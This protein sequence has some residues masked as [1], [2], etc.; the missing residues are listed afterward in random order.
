MNIAHPS[1]R[2]VLE[3]FFS[4]AHVD[5]PL[6]DKLAHHL[7]AM[8]REGLITQWHDRRINASEK[9]AKEI[10]IHLN[11]AHIILLLVSSDFI[12]SDYC[13]GIELTRAMERSLQNEARL[14]PI[15]LRPCDWHGM[16][17]ARLQALPTNGKPITSWPN[18]DEAFTDV[19][20]QLRRTI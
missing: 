13:F 17:F 6:R 8:Q 11:T 2:E 16:P 4:Y 14:V 7:S 3:L 10:D 19:A 12:A 9:W 1:G 18:I 5:E 15:I 20:R